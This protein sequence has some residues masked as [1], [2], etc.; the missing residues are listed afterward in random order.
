MTVRTWQAGHVEKSG[1]SMF[2]RLIALLAI[3]AAVTSA[4][5]AGPSLRPD[6]AIAG[7]SDGVSDTAA[8]DKTANAPPMESPASELDWR[9]C[10][11][12]TLSARELSGGPDG[13]S[14]ECATLRG[15]L[16]PETTPAGVDIDLMRATTAAT[17]ADAPPMVLTAGADQPST[18]ALAVLATGPRADLL[19]KHPLVAVDRR[20]LGPSTDPDCMTST[21]R[22]R[23][24]EAAGRTADPSARAEGMMGIVS[25]ATV[26]CTDMLRPAISSQDSLHA[27]ADLDTLRQAWGV[28]RLALL[29]VGSGSRVALTYAAELPDNLSRLVLDSPASLD[30][31]AMTIA[32]HQAQADQ[33]ALAALVQFCA[34]A[35]CGLGPDPATTIDGFLGKVR[36]GGVPNVSEGAAL[37]A[38]RQEMAAA[39]APWEERATRLGLLLADANAGN[40]DAINTLAATIAITDGQFTASC[41]D[42]P[43]PAT[44]EQ[45]AEVQPKWQAQYP[46][47][48]ADSAV[49]MLVCA[50]W[51]SHTPPPA[52]NRIPIP[53][54]LLSGAADPVVGSGSADTV[55][56]A[57]NRTGTKSAMVSWAGVG[58]GAL[59]NSDCAANAVTS[60]L[61]DGLLPG[62]QTACPA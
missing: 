14:L 40:P 56:A 34:A 26:S 3:A 55:S 10:T 32:E 6:M 31:D 35:D 52:T 61:E 53:V 29:A 25:E 22:L 15:E 20:G 57:L 21:D 24:T 38:I 4:C 49:R 17:P 43:S 44:P 54:L 33:T 19:E 45:S 30:S 18:D 7:H 5:A 9:D 28:D 60:Y 36:G 1:V 11:A 13:L 58:H 59:W 16:D 42:A 37:S 8:P 46:Q 47:F 48:G 51:P 27:A 50:A 2:A 12:R 23:L 39:D 62:L 41:S